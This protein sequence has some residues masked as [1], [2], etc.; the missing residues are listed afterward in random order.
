MKSTTYRNTT[1]GTIK[2]RILQ[3]HSPD[4]FYF[5]HDYNNYS[6]F[7]LKILTLRSYDGYILVQQTK[8]CLISTIKVRTTC[9][10][11]CINRKRKNYHVRMR[12]HCI[13]FNLLFTRIFPQRLF[14]QH[15]YVVTLHTFYNPILWR[16]TAVRIPL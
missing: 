13:S 3:V 10:M 9:M 16:P 11:R 4:D 2:K 8:K 6:K 15:N 7:S 5:H 1:I 12:V 14:T